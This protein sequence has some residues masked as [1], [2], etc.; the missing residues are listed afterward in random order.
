MPVERPS[1]RN[2]V[3]LGCD[4]TSWAMAS[5]GAEASCWCWCW[6]EG[7]LPYLVEHPG[8]PQE[9]AEAENWIAEVETDPR[10]GGSKTKGSVRMKSPE[11]GPGYAPDWT[12][13]G[14][15]ECTGDDVAEHL[16]VTGPGLPLPPAPE[17]AASRNDEYE[18]NH[19]QN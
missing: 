4:L 9:V 14:V 19:G 6:A 11:E 1:W 17:V 8:S 2:S 3:A 12:L 7:M 18:D 13:T 10:T 5:E 15:L 16:C